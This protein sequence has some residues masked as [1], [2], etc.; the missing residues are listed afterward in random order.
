MRLGST[1]GRLVGPRLNTHN[2]RLLSTWIGAWG[3]GGGQG[4][5]CVHGWGRRRWVAS[6]A[7]D[8]ADGDDANAG[9]GHARKAN[10]KLRNGPHEESMSDVCAE[11]SCPEIVCVW[12]YI[13][14][15]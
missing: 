8:C 14:C 12:F 6:G 9:A 3:T 7:A 1:A 15:W 5:P 4:A 13:F 2:H 11:R 10:Q